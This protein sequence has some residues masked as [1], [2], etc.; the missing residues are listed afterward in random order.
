MQHACFPGV[1]EEVYALL[2][3]SSCELHLKLSEASLAEEQDVQLLH[4][5]LRDAS[6]LVAF[7]N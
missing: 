6:L 5:R 4:D 3:I 7:G 1:F 2:A